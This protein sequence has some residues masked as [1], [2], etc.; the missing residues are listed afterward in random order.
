MSYYSSYSSYLSSV[1]CCKNGNQSSTGT[2]VTGPTGPAGPRGATGATGPQGATGPAGPAGATGATGPQGAQGPAGATGPVGPAGAAGP[3]GPVGATG[4]QGNQGIQGDTGPTGPQGPTGA[5]GSATYVSFT[6][7]VLSGF[8][9]ENGTLEGAY[10]QQGQQTDFYI[11]VT[12]GSSSSIS[13][14][15]QFGLP[16]TMT[17][18]FTPNFVVPGSILNGQA[19]FYDN[20]TGN[21]LAGVVT[22]VSSTSVEAK[23]LYLSGNYQL[24]QSTS[25]TA[26]FTWATSDEIFMIWSV[27]TA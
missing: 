27:R 12:L 7:E 3:T 21:R 26:P 25:A 20:S 19:S 10:A 6:P 8:T 22:W 5:A 23:V 24:Q 15:V 17:F 13:G 2:G 1:A 9:K 11:R 4:P 14:A 18:A 16:L